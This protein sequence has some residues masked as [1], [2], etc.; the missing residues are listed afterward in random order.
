MCGLALTAVMSMANETKST[1]GWPPFDYGLAEASVRIQWLP[2]HGLPQQ[3]LNLGG[4][5]RASFERDGSTLQ[6][7]LTTDEFL[8]VVNELYRLR[9]FDLAEQLRPRRSVFMKE[10]GSVGTQASKMHDALT[11]KVC[12]SLSQFTKCVAYEAG[13][14]LE[15]DGLV[16]RLGAEARQRVTPPT[17]ALPTSLKK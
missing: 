4:T 13:P 17:D 1:D 8:G 6:F 16:Q 5:G 11:T 2:S 14:P 10:D 3:T 9:F 7:T 12:F 15:L